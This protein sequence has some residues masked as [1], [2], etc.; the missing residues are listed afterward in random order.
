MK[1]VLG[2]ALMGLLCLF[3]RTSAAVQLG[4]FA[5][6]IDRLGSTHAQRYANDP[7]YQAL[8]DDLETL[9]DQPLIPMDGV[10]L[11]HIQINKATAN[12]E[13]ILANYILYHMGRRVPFNPTYGRG[14]GGEAYTIFNDEMELESHLYHADLYFNFHLIG[15]YL[16]T[17]R[18]VDF[19]DGA[20]TIR[21]L[22]VN[23]WRPMPSTAGCYYNSETSKAAVKSFYQ[24]I[25]DNRDAII[26]NSSDYSLHLNLLQLLGQTDL[27]APDQIDILPFGFQLEFLLFVNEVRALF[28]DNNIV[29][30]SFAGVALNDL[31]NDAVRDGYMAE[32]GGI[33]EKKITAE[34]AHAE[35]SDYLEYMNQQVLPMYYLAK[36]SGWLNDGNRMRK[37]ERT[38]DWLLKISDASGSIPRVDDAAGGSA[39][40]ARNY[41]L[42]P[43]AEIMQDDRFIDYTQS[44]NYRLPR[45]VAPMA[46]NQFAPTGVIKRFLTYPIRIPPASAAN[47]IFRPQVDFSGGVG[48]VR[49]FD[50]LDAAVDVAILA[51]NGLAHLEGAGHDQQDNGSISLNRLPVAGGDIDRLIIDPGYAGARARAGTGV[52]SVHNSVLING[53]GVSP[54]AV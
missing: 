21:G 35:G 16:L 10:S 1:K 28:G 6:Y 34:G 5:D 39:D 45:F 11:E 53:G 43:Y 17:R 52:F 7:V 14:I 3:A 27:R 54:N 51:E 42:A 8:Y 38:G 44:P 40:G 29:A 41:W 18:T 48:K 19:C 13:A 25:W 47:P 50:H 37:Y 30:K 33:V 4:Q 24:P 15:F 26:L 2:L 23:L 9:A 12:T 20:T 49:F 31:P 36:V 32:L 22:F 46:T